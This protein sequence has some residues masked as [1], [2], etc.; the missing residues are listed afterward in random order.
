MSDTSLRVAITGATG[1]L[2]DALAAWLRERGTRS[3]DGGTAPTPL[4]R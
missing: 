2:G 3:S 4:L 1:L